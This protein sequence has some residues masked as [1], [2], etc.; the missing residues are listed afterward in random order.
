LTGLVAYKNGDLIMADVYIKKDSLNK[1]Q[2]ADANKNQRGLRCLQMGHS[3]S[4][5]MHLMKA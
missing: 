5:L 3:I 1:P 2:Y 4:L